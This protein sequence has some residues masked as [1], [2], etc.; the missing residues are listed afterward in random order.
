MCNKSLFTRELAKLSISSWCYVIEGC[1]VIIH[2]RKHYKIS[3]KLNLY[4]KHKTPK[5][6]DLALIIQLSRK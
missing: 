5:A 2:R 1:S 6:I 3:C 4:A